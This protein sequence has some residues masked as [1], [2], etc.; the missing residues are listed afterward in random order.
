MGVKGLVF[1]SISK[2][3][4]ANAQVSVQGRSHAGVSIHLCDLSY[5]DYLNF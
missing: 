3:P 2:K 5:D 1:D 4:I